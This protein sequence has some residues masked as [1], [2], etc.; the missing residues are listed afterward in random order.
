[1]KKILLLITVIL[2]ILVA[3]V[4]VRTAGFESKQLAVEQVDPAR[5]DSAKVSEELSKSLQFQTLSHEDRSRL[6][7]ETFLALHEYL[8]QAYPLVH[9]ELEPRKINDLSLLYTWQ[10]SD[11]DLK[12]AVFMAHT[13]V[14][15][16]EPGTEEDWTHPAYSGD[17]AEGFVWGRGAMDDKGPVITI[18]HAAESL[19][20][21]GYRPRR[22]FYFAFGHDEEVGGDEGARRIAEYLASQNVTLDF[23]IDE[24]GAIVDGSMVGLAGS[25]LAAVSI[26]EKGFASIHLTVETPGG[27]SSVPPPN[28]SIGILA[29]AISRLES[30]QLPGGIRPPVSQML[31][32]LGP[33]MPF[34]RKMAFANMW[35][36]EGLIER[37][38]EA[39]PI[40]NAM[41]RTTTAATIFN[42]G[43][44]AN[45]LPSAARAVIN[46]R[47]LPGDTVDTV[48]E[49]V[50]RVIDDE[51]VQIAVSEEARDPSPV[52][53]LESA[54]WITLQ[55]TIR[56]LYPD[57]VV[58]PSLLVGGSDSK[59][60]AP[61]TDSVYRFAAVRA[62]EDEMGRAHGTDERI[63][64]ENLEQMTRFFI[65]LIRNSS[66]QET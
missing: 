27:H 12:P 24:G 34:S 26:A 61:L 10:G 38:F 3:V 20:E 30:N 42:A 60:F 56:E 58:V 28:T 31:E 6:D 55:K 49:H 63:S 22:T 66:D 50:R 15:P 25:L 13:D 32:Y 9:A 40:T 37:F 43:V 16:V 62:S 7:R 46:F 17:I 47:I 59:H 48:V 54:S 35:L 57:A 41:T 65:H 45:V 52:S 44:K 8:E 29:E 1:M 36:F 14:V 51:R 64:L 39:S 5:V 19:L 33:E 21:Q 18:L 4:V 2:L 53:S 11:P 23:V